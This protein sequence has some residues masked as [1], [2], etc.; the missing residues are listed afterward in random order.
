M[1]EHSITERITEN[2]DW[3]PL[4]EW[5]AFAQWC[6]VDESVMNMW[7]HRAYVPTVKI[8]KRRLVNLV[9]LVEDLKGEN[10]E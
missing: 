10:Q 3:P 5:R 7:V 6:R 8:G 4:M 2:A 9:R 1:L